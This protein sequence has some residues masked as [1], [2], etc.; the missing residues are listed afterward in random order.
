MKKIIRDAGLEEK[1]YNMLMSKDEQMNDLGYSILVPYLDSFK[2]FT[3]FRRQW[4][5]GKLRGNWL[6]QQQNKARCKLYTI[7]K[8][9]E[10]KRRFGGE[11]KADR[12]A[13]GQRARTKGASK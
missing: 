1:A 9:V 8:E 2:K 3:R 11:R 13:E 4:F 10:D 5:P 12:N 6:S 7:V